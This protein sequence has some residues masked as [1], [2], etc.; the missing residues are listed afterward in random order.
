MKINNH[1]IIASLKS[2]PTCKLI[3]RIPDLAEPRDSTSILE[4]LPRK[5]DIERHSPTGILHLKWNTVFLFLK[6]YMKVSSP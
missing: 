3:N 4:T 1:V 2:E 6:F 5:H